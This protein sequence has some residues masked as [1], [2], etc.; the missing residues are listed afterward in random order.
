MKAKVHEIIK[1]WNIPLSEAALNVYAGVGLS[2]ASTAFR[3]ITD[4]DLLVA[5]SIY[6][7]CAALA[8]DDALGLEILREFVPRFYSRQ[9]Q[10]SPSL[11]LFVEALTV[12]L[13]KHYNTYNSNAIVSSSLE[14]FN[15]EMFERDGGAKGMVIGPAS[16]PYLDYIRWKSGIGEPY[17][18]L[19]WPKYLCPDT[20]AYIQAIPCVLF[21]P[22]TSLPQTDPVRFPGMLSCS[23]AV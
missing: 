12:M 1:S 14:F 6:S 5:I 16:A 11:D 23:S 4:V 20:K 13:P 22:L 7:F 17:A 10:L 8:D 21:S 2:A 15:A 9:P 3:Y 19:I 18:C